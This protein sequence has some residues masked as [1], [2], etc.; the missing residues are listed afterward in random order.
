[1]AASAPPVSR[2]EVSSGLKW[3]VALTA[4]AL[5]SLAAY[6]VFWLAPLALNQFSPF[7][8][9]AESITR[10]L[11]ADWHGLAFYVAGCVILFGLYGAALYIVPRTDSL[12][13]HVAVFF[14]LSAPLLLLYTYP[15]LAADP[16]DYLMGGRIMAEYGLNPYVRIALEFIGDPYL[17]PVG[18]P[19]TPFIY[20]PAWAYVMSAVL[21][22]SGDST[23]L[24]L[25]L[26]KALAIASHLGVAAFVY[27]IARDRRPRQARTALV[28]Y[29][30]NPLVIIH[31]ALDGHNDAFMLLLVV[32]SLY[33]ALRHNWM[34]ALP[35]LTLGGLVKF[36]PFVLVPLFLLAGRRRV[37]A[38][39]AGLSISALLV[40]IAY[41]PL[42]QGIDTFD[43]LRDQAGRWT[44]SPVSLLS[45]LLPD[46][47]LRPLGVAL[48][49]AGYALVLRARLGLVEGAFAVLLLYLVAISG[50]TKGWYFAWPLA[51]AAI[52]GGWPLAIA[53]AASAG[54]FLMNVFGG[55]GWI[56]HWWEWY[57]RWGEWMM[58]IWLTL[59]LYLPPLLVA[60]AWLTIVL[61]QRRT[62][63]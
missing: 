62:S 17:P 46:E 9:P 16:F 40:A 39:V 19:A 41:I 32:A 29:A 20:G 33:F 56:M 34:L 10:I 30:W 53:V 49:A 51:L 22:L 60:I 55:W 6:G 50:W 21:W 8:G 57:V 48:F 63:P 54:A 24:A 7:A 28:A 4:V 35:L 27:L 5:L 45:F 15:A 1:M 59:S 52:L 13:L 43:G 11:G 25:L 47:A 12:G 23:L 26:V 38:L 31:F 18:W 61:R 42:W 58:E 37:E 14:T 2:I 3:T 44:S 36:V